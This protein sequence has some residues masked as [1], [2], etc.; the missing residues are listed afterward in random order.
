MAPLSLVFLVWEGACFPCFHITP[1]QLERSPS[2][3][4]EYQVLVGPS[5]DPRVGHLFASGS[6]KGTLHCNLKGAVTFLP[7]CCCPQGH[8]YRCL[9]TSGPGPYLRFKPSLVV[10]GILPLFR[11]DVSSFALGKTLHG[12]GSNVSCEVDGWPRDPSTTCGTGELSREV[13]VLFCVFPQ[14]GRG[15]GHLGCYFWPRLRG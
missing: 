6:R 11:T 8:T 1:S 2:I 4:F 5:N 12:V 3:S 9:V 10:E 7:F 13:V 15:G 14:G